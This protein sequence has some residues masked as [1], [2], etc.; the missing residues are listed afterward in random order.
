MQS[1]GQAGMS[2]KNSTPEAD[3]IEMDERI[4]AER[5]R[6]TL[7]RKDLACECPDSSCPVAHES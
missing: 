6:A 2:T 5:E 7:M 1:A 3:M 4:E